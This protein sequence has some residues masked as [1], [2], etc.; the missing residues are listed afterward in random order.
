MDGCRRTNDG[1]NN[2]PLTKFEVTTTRLA[3]LTI[4]VAIL[5]IA[6]S[7]LTEYKV[8]DY[9]MKQQISF[10]KQ[11][12]AEQL[13]I[14]ITAMNKTLQDYAD[15]YSKNYDLIVKDRIDFGS[16]GDSIIIINSK[17]GKQKAVYYVDIN[18]GTYNTN[19]NNLV[20]DYS[21][22]DYLLTTISTI[23]DGVSNKR[24]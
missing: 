16:N 3:L 24:L 8:T 13:S 15:E 19:R 12:T 5:S 2:P 4:A 20:P 6:A 7:I 1:T 9:Q 10:D 22:G 23:P 11:A 18:K 21:N 17:N 14:E